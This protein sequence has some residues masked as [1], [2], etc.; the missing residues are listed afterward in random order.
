MNYLKQGLTVIYKSCLALSLAAF[1]YNEIS[2]SHIKS[3]LVSNISNNN[4]SINATQDQPTN[5]TEV[6]SADKKL[7]YVAK[8]S[9]TRTRTTIDET[10]A[11][12]NLAL[13][14]FD[15]TRFHNNAI[16]DLVQ[17]LSEDEFQTG[18]PFDLNKQRSVWK[19]LV[20]MNILD[21]QRRV[22]RSPQFKDQSGYDIVAYEFHLE[23]DRKAYAIARRTEQD[24]TTVQFYFDT[25]EEGWI[26]IE[27][28]QNQDHFERRPI[29]SH[30]AALL[31][32]KTMTELS[33]PL[34]TA[35][36]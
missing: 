18:H 32:I 12:L 5:E 19:S 4:S 23:R 20:Q 30:L 1:L 26:E 2:Q 3:L 16:K 36:R 24:L 25:L 29:G 27:Q 17:Q 8:P 31:K 15:L 9:N 14:W 33:V 21:Y 11:E 10:L 13:S 22:F 6:N 7:Q 28:V 34:L 35:G